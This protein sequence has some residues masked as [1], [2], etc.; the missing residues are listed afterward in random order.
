MTM[1]ANVRIDE[2]TLKANTYYKYRNLK[3]F[4]RFLDV[5]VN[6]RLYG[7]VYKELNDPMEGKFNTTGLEKKDF[8]EIYKRLKTTR[9]CSLLTKQKNQSFPDDYLMWSHYA[10]SHK[11]CCFELQ[12]SNQYNDGWKLLAVK[13]Q[14]NLPII[15]PTKLDE[16]IQNI[17]SVKTTIWENEHEVRAVKQYED[18]KF[19]IQS[20]FYHVKVNAIYFGERVTKKKCDFYRKVIS[21]IRPEIQLYRMIEDKTNPGFFP[22]LFPKPM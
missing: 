12:H 18:D 14:D 1:D 16:G 21:R 11:G 15:D 2:E 4:E 7:A 10:D 5:V 6:R 20:E 9:I 17:L 8:D 3:D 13:Y 19:S 22:K